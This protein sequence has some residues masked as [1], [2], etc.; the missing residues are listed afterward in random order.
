MENSHTTE[1]KSTI[2]ISIKSIVL[3]IVLIIIAAG[4]A[5]YFL[6]YAPEQKKK[7]DINSYKKS[8]YESIL[9]QYQCPMKNY[10]FQNQTQELQDRDCV[11]N[12]INELKNKGYLK[13]QFSNNEINQDSLAKDIEQVVED[14]RQNSVNNSTGLLDSQKITNC[15]ISSLQALKQNYSY[16]N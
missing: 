6:K 16:L 9:C 4:L 10:T 12:C 15:A 8:L 1:D 7:N 2:K 11:V 3:V 5:Y 13:D 14:C